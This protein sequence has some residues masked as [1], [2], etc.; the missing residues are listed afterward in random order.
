[1]NELNNM[2]SREIWCSIRSKYQAGK[3]LHRSKEKE[4]QKEVRFLS[5]LLSRRE[6]NK[7][8]KEKNSTVALWVNSN[9]LTFL[10]VQY[11]CIAQKSLNKSNMPV[12]FQQKPAGRKQTCPWFLDE[13]WAVSSP[14]LVKFG[15]T[16]T[17]LCAWF[18]TFFNTI[19]HSKR[20]EEG[21]CR[22]QHKLF[23][24]ATHL[25]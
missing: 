10:N 24:N 25:S 14:Q 11:G 8:Q 12:H 6:E 3:T 20:L 7:K 13:L 15:I 23:H 21:K 18:S 5:R 9:E 1:M 22:N 4:L 19:F 17:I 2:T 16:H